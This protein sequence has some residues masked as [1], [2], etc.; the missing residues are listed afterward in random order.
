MYY[1]QLRKLSCYP[2]KNRDNLCYCFPI[3]CIFQFKFSIHGIYSQK[4]SSR[5][6]SLKI[7]MCFF[8]PESRDF[9]HLF[10]FLY[11][12]LMLNYYKAVF[13]SFNYLINAVLS[14]QM[15]WW[16][17]LSPEVQVSGL[18]HS[19]DGKF[20]SFFTKQMESP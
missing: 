1:N 13:S 14:A 7:K 8:Y 19:T 9:R 5:I 10:F 16:L 17:G 15:G 6:F 18:T 3:K 12:G 2:M 4:L 20:F 11:L